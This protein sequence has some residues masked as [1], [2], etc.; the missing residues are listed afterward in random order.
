MKRTV[1]ILQV[2]VVWTENSRPYRRETI[3]TKF[4]DVLIVLEKAEIKLN[5]SRAYR[6]AREDHARPLRHREHVFRDDTKRHMK[7]VHLADA[8][9]TLYIPSMIT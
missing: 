5:A 9:N 1:L 6:L 8:I 2:H 7:G 3:A 4:C